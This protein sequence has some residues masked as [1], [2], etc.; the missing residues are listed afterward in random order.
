MR[1]IYRVT[2]QGHTLESTDVRKLLSRAVEE[3][4][5]RSRFAIRSAGMIA[6]RVASIATP[7]LGAETR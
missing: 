2:I 6:T 5:N 4:R 3:K 1:Q 7:A